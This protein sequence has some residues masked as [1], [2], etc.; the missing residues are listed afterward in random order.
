MAIFKPAR[1]ARPIMEFDVFGNEDDPDVLWVM[2]W[3]N[4]AGSRHERWFVD[5]LVDVGYRVHAAAVPTNGTDFQA[6]YVDPLR[7]YRN[8]LGEHRIVSHSTGGLAVAHLRP[9]PP[10]VYL[11]PWWGLGEETPW[12]GTILFKL[13]IATP[14][15]PAPVE[16]SVLGDLATE[17]DVTAPEKLSPA[18]M[19][20][21]TD[22]QA[23]LPPIKPEDDVFYCPDDEVVSPTAIEAHARQDQLHP[24][25]GGHEF[26]ASAGR[27]RIVERVLDALDRAFR[28]G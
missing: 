23:A 4:R 24:Y 22:A 18:W 9:G 16:P 6:D 28:A 21:I 20:T 26:F 13:P 15:I 27:D 14:V 25:D 17:E 10:A 3:G 19:G 11:S 8:G 7:E 2:G 12:I 1:P 5:E